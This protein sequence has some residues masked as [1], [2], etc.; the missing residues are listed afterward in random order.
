MFTRRPFS[1]PDIC[2]AAVDQVSSRIAPHVLRT[3]LIPWPS[4]GALIGGSVWIKLENE[5]HTGSFKVRGA[6][7]ALVA[8]NGQGE[9]ER[10]ASSHIVTASSGNHGAAVAY[11][12]AQLGLSARVFVPQGASVAKVDRIRSLGAT[13]E[14]FGTD[15]LDTELHAR[16]LA[17]QTGARYVS[18]YNDPRVVAGQGTVALEM[19][20]E[21]PELEVLIAAVGGGGLIGGMAAAARARKPGIRLIGASP[22]ASPIMAESVRAGQIIERA[23]GP[24]LSDGTSGGVEPGS[25]TFPLCAALIDEWIDVDES[26][27]ALWMRRGYEELGFLMEG[28]AAVAVAACVSSAARLSGREVGIVICGGNV[29]DDTRSRVL[30]GLA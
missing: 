4:L 28:A 8:P 11:A 25:I 29:S 10:D 13:V 14:R 23:V 1:Q 27:I 19:L 7:S 5:Q 16:A 24:T 15:G 18:P 9:E 21:R 12:S 17:A 3:R 2:A 6:F 20:A 22:A 26:N 30:G